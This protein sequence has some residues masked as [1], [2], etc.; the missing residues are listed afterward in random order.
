MV[1]AIESEDREITL[2]KLLPL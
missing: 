2:I 1:G